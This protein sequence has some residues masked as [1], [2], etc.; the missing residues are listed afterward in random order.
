[1]NILTQNN[2]LLFPKPVFSTKIQA[3]LSKVAKTFGIF[4]QNF[5]LVIF[6]VVK[7][8]EGTLVKVN[9]TYIKNQ[10]L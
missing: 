8:L 1:L 9:L 3:F 6:A 2:S 4:Y 10:L 5:Y 7:I